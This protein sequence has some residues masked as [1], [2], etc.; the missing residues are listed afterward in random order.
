MSVS[1]GWKKK[2][3]RKLTYIDGGSQLHKI[4]DEHFRGFPIEL[5][6]KDIG[7]LMGIAACGHSGAQELL[8]AIYSFETI[9]VDADW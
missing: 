6:E 5:G 1:L 7:V 8:D 2:D 4:L 9:V 3:P